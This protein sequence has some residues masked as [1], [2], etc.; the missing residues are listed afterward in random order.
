MENKLWFIALSSAM[1]GTAH[2]CLVRATSKEEAQAK[3]DERYPP[4]KEQQ[5]T[6]AL[7]SCLVE[8]DEDGISQ[9]IADCW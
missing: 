4:A 9:V 6:T 7:A 5:R 8:F 1:Y 3:A 2:Y